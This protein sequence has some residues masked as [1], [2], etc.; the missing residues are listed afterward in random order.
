M[1]DKCILVNVVV[2]DMAVVW[3]TILSQ[4]LYWMIYLAKLSSRY[5]SMYYF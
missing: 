3:F 5:N 1:Y 2:K 4:I